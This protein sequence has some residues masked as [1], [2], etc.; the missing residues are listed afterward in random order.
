MTLITISRESGSYGEEITELVAKTLGL[1]HVDRTSLEKELIRH[2]IPQQSVEKYD[3]KKPSF[4]D[5]F[6]LD[7]DR[8]YHYLKACMLDTVREGDH[9]IIGRGAPVFLSGIPGV[10]HVRITA[11]E[12]VRIGRI[13]KQHECA[14]Q[15]ARKLVRQS[16]QNRSGYYRVFFNTDWSSPELYDMVFNTDKLPVKAVAE[17]IRA[18]VEAPEFRSTGQETSRRIADMAT[19]QRIL[20][21]ILFE[22]QIPLRFATVDV[23]DGVATIGGAVGV[24]TDTKR[25][26]AIASET[27]G[28]KEVVTQIANVPETYEGPYM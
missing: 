5:L 24:D 23:S 27:E 13:M 14:E 7:R 6:S 28:I 17:S 26:I 16:D 18:V 25:C 2:G 15:H 4:W 8:Y 12:E 11:S 1:R 22:E 19:A 9:V 10:L 21:R 20:T 3:E